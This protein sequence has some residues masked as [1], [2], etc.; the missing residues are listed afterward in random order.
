MANSEKVAAIRRRSDVVPACCRFA[1]VSITALCQCCA[2]PG[3]STLT[4]LAETGL[5]PSVK[6]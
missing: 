4:K 3:N 1:T 2:T 5:V 6:A